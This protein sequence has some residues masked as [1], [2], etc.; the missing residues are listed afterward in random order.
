M[1]RWNL[2]ASLLAFIATAG[3]LTTIV[4]LTD[5]VSAAAEL[6]AFHSSVESDP[7]ARAAAL[8]DVMDAV[9]VAGLERG[10]EEARTLAGIE[11]SMLEST[12]EERRRALEDE[13]R[14]ATSDLVERVMRARLEARDAKIEEFAAAIESERTR[15]RLVITAMLV[16]AGVS[17]LVL[18]AVQAMRTGARTRAAAVADLEATRADLATTRGELEGAVDEKT[19]ALG[20]ALDE[21]HQLN[22]RLKEVLSKLETAQALL[23][24]QEKMAALG[25]LA[26]GV[27]HEFNNILGGIRGC[28]EDLLE[29]ASDPDTRETLEVVVRAARRGRTIV[30][31]LMTFSRGAAKESEPVNLVETVADVIRLAAPEA[32]ES[33]VALSSSVVGDPSTADPGAAPATVSGD[34]VALHQVILNLVKNAIQASA[35]GTAV[36]IAVVTEEDRVLLS[37]HD[38]GPGVPAA[39]RER[40]FEPF[41]TTRELDGG[42]GLGLAISH[43]IVQ[44]LGGELR[45][46]DRDGGGSTF[47]AAL[48][49]ASS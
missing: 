12:V 7:E 13:A 40:I 30:D 15:G 44:G 32:E 11:P 2:A 41:F 20:V 46:H 4:A 26:G 47:V 29:E 35:D 34:P 14:S 49:L 31:G 38:R 17:A 39:D 9:R 28:A 45:L 16:L 22:D 24:Q 6:R 21:S 23:V 3:L 42:S 33:G 18:S 48:P 36:E 8:R 27:A 1:T 25:T 37:V 10:L 5:D 43:G 19:A